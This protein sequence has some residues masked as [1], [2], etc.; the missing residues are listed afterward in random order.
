MPSSQ[1]LRQNAIAVSLEDG[2]AGVLVRR[3]GVDG[4]EVGVWG[5]TGGE[6]P[7][8]VPL[9]RG[10][11]DR[12]DAAGDAIV[13]ADAAGHVAQVGFDGRALP[14]SVGVH[15]R[16][17]TPLAGPPDAWGLIV[18]RAGGEIVGGRP[19]EGRDG[20]LDAAWSVA[21]TLPALDID[22]DAARSCLVVA[23]GSDPDRPSM[24]I[25]STPGGRAP[26]RRV[27]LRAPVYLGIVPVGAGGGYVVNSAN[28]GPHHVARAPRSERSPPLA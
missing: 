27:R 9:L 19:V 11:F 25:H 10:A 6:R 5:G 17:A 26:A 28:R 23:D 3:E 4:P 1:R 7:E 14:G 20:K 2:R 13:F 21:G 18:D 22:V 12:A 15:G 24:A 8:F 16:L